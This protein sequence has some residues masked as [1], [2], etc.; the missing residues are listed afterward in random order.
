MKSQIIEQ[1]GQADILLPSLVAEGLAANDRIK[2]RMS[3]L[4]AASRHAQQPDR[5]AAD[6]QVEC[7]AAGIPAAALATLIGGAHLAGDG[8]I[9][10]PNLAKLMK[11]IHDDVAAMIR[12]VSAGKPSEAETVNARLAAIRT[13][14]TLEASNEIEIARI[15]RLTGIAQEGAD[16]LHRLVID[17]HKELNQLA[18]GC[19][20]EILSGAHVFGLHTEDRAAVESFM[21]GLNQTRALKFNHP[22][23]ETMATR[24]GGRLLIQNDIGTTDAHVLVIAIKKNSVTVTYTDVHRARAKFFIALFDKF[25]AKWSGLDRHTATGLG[26]DNA[27]YL[28]TGRYQADSAAD[29]NAFLAAIGGALVFL[30]DWNKAR[31]L[32][33]NWVAKDDAARILEW[34]ARQRI[35]HRAF[36]ELGGNELLGAAVR[37]A[38]PARIG[39]GERLDQALGRDV[40]IDF[41]KTAI[42]VSSEALSAGRSVSWSATRSRRILSGI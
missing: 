26:D 2:V 1:L 23:L 16:S 28:V 24:S 5:P 12:A 19:A 21:Q 32:L 27:F 31:K 17:L 42:R 8:R 36:L 14:G 29:R 3:A 13:A 40:A 30:I 37:N 18:A 38:A 35:G 22:G 25:Q 6:L 33:R 15:A 9:A 11:E 41:L 4:Q 7:S 34:A 20:E 39:F 10:A